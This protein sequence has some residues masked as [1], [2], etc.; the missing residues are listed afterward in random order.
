MYHEKLV[1]HPNV[2]LS[3]TSTARWGFMVIFW[4]FAGVPFVSPLFRLKVGPNSV[5]KSYVYS[6]VYMARQDPSKYQFSTPRYVFMFVILL[7][8]YYVSVESFSLL[9]ILADLLR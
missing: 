2:Y 3:L 1:A 5:I 8:A 4:N 7:T 6:I 9:N